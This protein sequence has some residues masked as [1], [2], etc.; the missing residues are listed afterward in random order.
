MSITT[1]QLRNF[2]VL[3]HGSTGKTSLVEHILYTGGTISKPEAV[4]TGKTVS[5]FKEDEISRNISI[6]TSLSSVHWNNI[7]INILDTPGSNDFVGEVVCALRAVDAALVVVGADVGVQIETIK[8]WRRLDTIGLP[9]CVFINKMDKEHADFLHCLQDLNDKFDVTFVPIVMPVGTGAEFS[10]VI[11]LLHEKGYLNPSG[12]KQDNLQDIPSEITEQ[13]VE[14][15]ESLVEAAAEGDDILIEKYF[16]EGTLT[17]EEM[18]TGLTGAIQQNKLV[19]VLCGSALLNSGINLLLNCIAETFRSPADT[20]NNGMSPQGEEIERMLKVQEPASVFAFK[21]S[22]DQFTGKLTYVKV[23]S[24]KITTDSELINVKEGKKER[25]SKMY[26]AVG[27]KLADVPE[28]IA[29]DI[30]ILAKLDSVRTNNTLS[31]PD[32]LIQYPDLELPQP[33]HSVTVS[34]TSKKDENKLAENLQKVT[35]EDLTFT[36]KFDTETKETVISGMGELHLMNILDKIREQHKV[37]ILTKIPKVA[38]RETITATSGAEYLHKKQTGGHGQYAKVVLEIIP[39]PRGE[40]F[41]FVKAIFGGAISKGYIPGVEKGI[42][43]GMESGIIAGY[44]VVDLEA[45]VIDGKEH[46]VDSS[47]MAFKLAAR[48]AVRSAME[49]AKPVLLEPVMS[50]SVFVEDKYLGDVLSDLSSRRGRVLGQESIGGGIQEIKAQVPMA[51]LL[52]Y[53]IDLRSITSGT[54]SFEMEF[55]HY[56]PITGRVAE[57][58]IKQTTAATAE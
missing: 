15:R 30:G 23:L 43:E 25:L 20:V 24:G 48:G 37:E 46:P 17:G 18:K 54:A 5:D 44:P 31:D 16:D 58:V 21:T 36:M 4:E 35:D 14:Y 19:P 22:I 10:G 28:I 55:D 2:V 8:L 9:R 52:R 38:Y 1:E 47:E 51:E 50:L 57:D 27:K 6:Y 56:N 12:E 53:S 34:A 3:G 39:L 11:D 7:K 42:L 40:N 33:V 29:G 41:S 13:V 32:S 49:K 45:K 26:T